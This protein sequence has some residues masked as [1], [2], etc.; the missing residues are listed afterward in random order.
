M[1][2]IS[3]GDLAGGSSRTRCTDASLSPQATSHQGMS[4]RT[5]TPLFALCIA[6][7]GAAVPG[8]ARGKAP[9]PRGAAPV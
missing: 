3:Y 1:E 5:V 7:V 8:S 2:T 4:L 9:R 6:P